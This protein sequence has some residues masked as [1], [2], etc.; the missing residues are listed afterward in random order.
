M[1]ESEAAVLS[2]R[3]ALGA[4]LG[5]GGMGEVRAA[6]DL[7]LGREVAIKLLRPDLARDPG[8][9]RRFEHEAR[10]AARLTHPHVVTVYDT[11]EDQGEAYLVMECL[12]G[13]TLADEM[14]AGPLPPERVVAVGTAI[15]GALT[16][17]HELGIVHRDIKP[18]NVLVAADGSPKVADFGIAKTSESSD[19]TG[20]GLVVGT[21]AY[22]APE[23]LRGEPASSRSDTY[24]VGVVLY[25]AL[26]GHRPYVG[27]TPAAVVHAVQSLEPVPAAELR[28]GV[29]PGLSATLARA[30][31]KDPAERFPSAAA[32][33]GALA[34]T[35][36]A[37][38]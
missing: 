30:M 3:Y 34:A 6:R 32:L 21:T 5:G 28:P 26:T 9:R 2:G 25:E 17:A 36:A 13:R 24:S 10:A 35:S 27:D 19:H 20:T 18:S 12:P 37:G 14:A 7:R 31:A 16:A 23:R 33:A 22:L 4:V 1:P 11:G 8:V 38:A 15:L 29:D